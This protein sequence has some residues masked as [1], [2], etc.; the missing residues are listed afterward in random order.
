MD[1][2]INGQK[3]IA[4]DD[5]IIKPESRGAKIKGTLGDFVDIKEY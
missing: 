1:V 5:F 3:L 4:G 2:E